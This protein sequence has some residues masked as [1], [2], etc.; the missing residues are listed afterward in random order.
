VYPTA[1]KRSRS[2]ER[3]REGDRERRR[4]PERKRH[5]SRDRDRKR[6]RSRDRKRDRKSKKDE[7]EQKVEEKPKI[8][9]VSLE[10]VLAKKKA[11]EE[12]LSKVNNGVG[13]HLSVISEWGIC[14]AA[15]IMGNMSYSHDFGQSQ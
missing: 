9:P 5:R 4:S 12:A 7:E 2:R 8:V 15:R 14:A 11:E 1:R 10:E 6:S 13:S 3:R